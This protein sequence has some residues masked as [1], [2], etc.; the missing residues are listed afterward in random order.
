MN[1]TVVH[2]MKLPP[3]P[4]WKTSNFGTELHITFPQKARK[5]EW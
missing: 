3:N 1:A 4:S 2:A 5:K